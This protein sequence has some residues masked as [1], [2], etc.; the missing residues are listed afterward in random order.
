MSRTLP[1]PLGLA[2]TCLRTDAGWTQQRLAEAAGSHGRVISELETGST[3]RTLSRETFERLAGLMG[4]GPEEVDLTMLYVAGLRSGRGE[5]RA[6][7][8]DPTP[9]EER[10]IGRIAAHVGLVEANRMRELLRQLARRRRAAAARGEAAALWEEVR[11]LGPARRRE[12]VERRP[13]IH[14]WALVERLCEESA[15]TAGNDPPRALELARLA[16]RVAELAPEDE[17]WRCR[18]QGFG[19]AFV[20]NALR[21]G[22]EQDLVAAEAAFAAAWRLWRAG[23]AAAAQGP[24]AEWRLLDL[25]AS[26]RRDLRQFDEALE[27]LRRALAAAPAEA[28]GRI[29]LKRSATL[30]QAGQLE[31]ALAALE[32][33]TPLVDAGG[34]R[35]ERMGIRFNRVATLCQLGRFAEAEAALPELRSLIEGGSTD[36]LRCLW[37]SGRVAAGRGRRAE[38]RRAF[39]R[40]ERQFARRRLAYDTALVALDLAALLLED[41]EPARVAKLAEAMVWIFASRRVHREALAALRLFVAAARAGSA[42][43]ELARRVLAF[44]ERARQDPRLRFADVP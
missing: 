27:L 33:A 12:L 1:P 28:A 17:G 30:E 44:L 19:Q 37:L 18:P 32:A 34:E 41:G 29:L 7:P 38:A 6:T 24:L 25:E 9:G 21:V 39:S 11:R 40:A 36:A 22:E 31:A 15:R 43:A 5:P 16:L 13:E 2:L 8:I 20:G 3:G 4:Y 26:L 10:R 14:G 23:G 35:R 42:T